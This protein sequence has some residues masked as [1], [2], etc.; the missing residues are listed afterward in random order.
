MIAGGIAFIIL[1]IIGLALPFLQGF[2][3]LAIGI[4]LLSLSSKAVRA[5]IRSYTEKYPRVDKALTKMEDWIRH[6]VGSE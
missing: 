4:V 6:I 5:R 3:F 2:L 1:G